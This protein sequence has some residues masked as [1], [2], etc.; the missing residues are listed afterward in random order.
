MRILFAGAKPQTKSEPFA[1]PRQAIGEEVSM[2]TTFFEFQQLTKD[3]KKFLRGLAKRRKEKPTD[4]EF[5]K[6]IKGYKNRYKVSNHGRVKSIERFC[7]TGPDSNDTRRVRERILKPCLTYGYFNVNLYSGTKAS[8]KR[9][10]VARLV[11]EAFE[12]PKPHPK[13]EACHR[14]DDRTNN[15]ISNLY[16]GTSK[17]NKADARRNG[18]MIKACGED[19]GNSKLT[20]DKVRKIRRLYPK[21]KNYSKLARR[22]EVEVNCIK[23]IVLNQTWKHVK[24]KP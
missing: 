10:S 11:L 9:K 16:W 15:H 19:H 5:W 8:M 1:D 14:D 3:K 24:E 6:W 22:F 2:M 17:Q 4:E 12:G 13:L 20:E 7:S 21:V 23:R 18:R